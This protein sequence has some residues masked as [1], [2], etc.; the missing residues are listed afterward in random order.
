MYSPTRV[1]TLPENTQ[2]RD[3]AVGDIHG[4]FTRL[5]H[6]LTM[7]EFDST[8]D[9]LFSVGDL[10]DR[11][12]ESL[13]SVKWLDKKWFYAV[14]GNHEDMAIRYANIGRMM[15]A[16]YIANGGAWFVVLPEDEQ[17]CFAAM[18]EQLPIII[19]VETPLGLVGIVHADCPSRSWNSLR[20]GLLNPPSNNTLKR[21]LGGCQW[22][23]DRIES[24]DV[25]VVED[26]RAVIVG[27][28]PVEDPVIL[29]NVF[30]IDTGGWYKDGGG[31]FTFL[32]L[33]TLE[34][35]PY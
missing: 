15:A 5:K 4:Q 33:K 23:R 25:S 24:S 18:F 17:K 21:I 16:N 26:I 34:V 10:V 20:E 13:D 22:S 27:H 6:A 9:R 35:I 1:L 7:I 12:P 2:G 11:G 19:E 29:G 30:H 28:T 14:Q 8:K 3:I 32:D 31:R